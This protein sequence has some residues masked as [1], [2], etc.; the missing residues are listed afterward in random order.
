[1]ANTKSRRS[2]RSKRN[3]SK[4]NRSRKNRNNRRMKGGN[5]DNFDLAKQH[6]S[7]VLCEYQNLMNNTETTKHDLEKMKNKSMLYQITNTLKTREYPN[8]MSLTEVMGSGYGVLSLY[9][10]NS[11]D[12]HASV[13]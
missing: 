7:K 1:M 9:V 12:C 13:I 2:I 11:I 6:N 3:L 4:K 8:P 10:D 5:P